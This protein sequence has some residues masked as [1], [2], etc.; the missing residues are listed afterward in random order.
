M[1]LEDTVKYM[2]LQQERVEING[3]KEDEEDMPKKDGIAVA[4]TEELKENLVLRSLMLRL[5][6]SILSSYSLRKWKSSQWKIER[7]K[8]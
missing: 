8:S 5:S 6:S 1:E 4:V 7:M 3:K 2:D